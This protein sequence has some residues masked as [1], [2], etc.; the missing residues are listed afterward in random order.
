MKKIKIYNDGSMPTLWN[1]VLLLQITGIA[2]W[3]FLP[4]LQMYD[5]MLLVM[6]VVT[7]LIALF[8]ED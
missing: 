5:V 1:R 3:L 8:C 6:V 7:P 4:R 2:A